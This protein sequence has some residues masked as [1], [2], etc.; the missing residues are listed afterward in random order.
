MVL[1]QTVNICIRQYIMYSLHSNLTVCAMLYTSIFFFIV[2]SCVCQNAL[3][4]LGVAVTIQYSIAW[5]LC[6]FIRTALPK[7]VHL[8]A[9]LLSEAVFLWTTF[10]QI[11]LQQDHFQQLQQQPLGHQLYNVPQTSGPLD[12]QQSQ[13]HQTLARNLQMDTTP[14]YSYP[15]SPY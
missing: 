11:W 3:K 10:Q 14:Q 7:P 2:K 5:Y 8:A 15:R 12:C 6:C 9:D 1:A 4:P 13:L